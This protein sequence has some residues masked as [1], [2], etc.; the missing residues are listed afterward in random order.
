MAVVVVGGV[1]GVMTSERRG[2]R[3]LGSTPRRAGVCGIN[4][5]SSCNEWEK[6]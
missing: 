3:I 5:L 6:S 4:P 1:R 2:D